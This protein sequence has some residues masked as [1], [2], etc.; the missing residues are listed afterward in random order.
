MMSLPFPTTLRPPSRSR[1]TALG[2]LPPAAVAALVAAALLCPAGARS[3][4]RPYLTVASAAAEE[5]DDQVW[6]VETTLLSDRGQRGMGLAVEYAFDPLRSFQI[7]FARSRSRTDDPDATEVSGEFKWLFNHIARDGW[8]TGL[9]ASLSTRRETGGDGAVR[10]WSLVAPLS[11][12]MGDD[13]ALVHLNVG[14]VVEGGERRRLRAF[15]VEREIAR[16]V[17]AFAEWSDLGGERLV[18]G[19]VRWW[20]RREKVALDLSTFSRRDETGTVRGWV[21]GLGWHDL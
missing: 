8:G 1:R 4:D 5:D 2:G 15:G 9:V 7:E 13:G 6:S 21:L 11:I 20:L 3:A 12:R 14:R 17:T 19:G 16:R 10:S 18:H